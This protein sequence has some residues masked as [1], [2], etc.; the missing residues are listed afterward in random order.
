MQTFRVQQIAVLA[1]AAAVTAAVPAARQAPAAPQ[2][3]PASLT[4]HEFWSLI[5]LLSETGGNFHGDNFT[6]NESFADNAAR[7]ATR[8][9]GGA[10]L[11]VGPEQNF[12]YI[13]AVRPQ[14]AFVIDI[15]R[16]AVIQH[17]LFKALFE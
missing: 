10:Y 15:R 2:T 16:Q 17:L 8:R 6:S 5:S 13:V 11:G 7:L 14:I 9:G 1:L 12:S 4:D 3:V